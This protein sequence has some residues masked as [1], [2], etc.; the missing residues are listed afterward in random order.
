[1]I[2]WQISSMTKAYVDT[3]VLTDVL[4][5]W[6]N[7]RKT[8]KDALRL[9][10]TTQLPVYAIKEFKAGP[11]SNFVWMHNKLVTLSS[12][13][14]ALEAL[15]RM[16]RTPKRYTTST[17]I[18]ALKLSSDSIGRLTTMDLLTKYGIQSSDKVLCNEYRLAIK[19]AVFKAWKKRRNVT[20]EVVDVLPCYRE[21][22]PYDER[23]CIVLDPLKCVGYNE[24]SLSTKLKVR[25]NEL[26]IL[27]DTIDKL[28]VKKENQRRSQ[29]LRQL[30]RKP[31]A[32][33]VEDNCRALGDAYFAI[34]CPNDSV[35]LTTN[36]SDHEPMA[37]ALGKKVAV[38]KKS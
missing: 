2:S 37:I 12:W 24:C 1:M 30:I 7:Q 8:A 21:A 28:P 31:K 38:P 29:V 36:R 19:S 3:T 35:I 25:S 17:A 11:L 20:T 26:K 9:Y 4:L 6:G 10:A 15:Q 18:Q 14:E 33:M 23:G 27:K 22:T 34:F 32:P 13:S 5:S 16:S